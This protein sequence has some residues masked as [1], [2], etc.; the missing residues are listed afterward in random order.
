M[1]FF[2]DWT[3]R[4]EID[5]FS[6]PSLIISLVALF[7]VVYSGTFRTPQVSMIAN[8]HIH[9]KR[10]TGPQ[11]GKSVVHVIAK[12]S[13]LNKKR[14]SEDDVI[15]SERAI[16]EAAG[17]KLT[18]TWG[19]R[20]DIDFHKN[21][22]GNKD[23]SR[24]QPLN[25]PIAVGPTLLRAGSVV[26][27][28]SHYYTVTISASNPVKRS[29]C[30]EDGKNLK[31]DALVAHERAGGDIGF[32]SEVKLLSGGIWQS[33]RKRCILKAARPDRRMATAAEGQKAGSNIY[34][35]IC[36]KA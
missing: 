12:R 28:T 6:A 17:C 29:Q 26:T 8:R 36:N 23:Y 22:S 7:S 34:A 3:I 10:Y 25:S 15:L 19:V 30:S 9:F 14:L 20:G 5:V 31:W 33:F 11:S 4:K 2:K 27:H 35:Y 21:A 32:R 13:Y 1:S 24:A 18:A 16:V